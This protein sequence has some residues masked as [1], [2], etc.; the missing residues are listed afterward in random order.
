MSSLAPLFKRAAPTDTHASKRAKLP[1]MLRGCPTPP[2][3]SVHA[4]SLLVKT[5]GEFEG[6]T[7]ATIRICTHTHTDTRVRTYRGLA[8]L[9]FL[10]LGLRDVGSGL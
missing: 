2:G 10:G 5:F 8:H 6:R 7:K 9:F 1:A 4:G 3:W